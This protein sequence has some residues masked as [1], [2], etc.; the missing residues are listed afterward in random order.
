MGPNQSVPHHLFMWYV[1]G[2]QIFGKL[3]FLWTFPNLFISAKVSFECLWGSPVE[4]LIFGWTPPAWILVLGWTS[5][6]QTL[7]FGW[8]PSAQILVFGWTSWT[9]STAHK[10]NFCWTSTILI[11]G[12]ATTRCFW[13]FWF[14][15]VIIGSSSFCFRFFI[16]DMRQSQN[17]GHQ[18]LIKKWTGL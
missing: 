1:H 14:D 10:L 18:R 17:I 6:T 4:I 2:P 5:S 12:W 3:K 7:I 8:T 16:F 9:S 13:S 15:G 11:F